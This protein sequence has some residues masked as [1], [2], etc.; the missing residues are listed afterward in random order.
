MTQN[1]D[2]TR[3]RF[4][5]TAASA[6]GLATVPRLP[7][8]AED[9]WWVGSLEHLLPAASH[10]RLAIKCSF[11]D[12]LDVVPMLR[13]G[14]REVA[15]RETDTGRRFFSFDLE[16]LE[17]DVEYALQ[18]IDSAGHSLCDPWPL[19]TFPGPDAEP[20]SVRLVAYTCAGGHPNDAEWFLP[21]DV[22]RRLLR[23]ALSFHPRAVIAIGDHIYWDQRTELELRGEANA[24]R[25]R[26]FYEGVG[27]LDRSLPALGTRNEASLKAAV[28]A[29]D[30]PAVRRDAALDAV[31]LRQRRPRLFR[32]RRR[33][34]AHGHVPPRSLSDRF[35]TLYS[36][37]L[38]PRVSP[39]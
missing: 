26:E 1:S 19:R 13:I 14:D 28:G 3:R 27:W 7:A 35:R 11:T 2:W 16:G 38:P 21:I 33:R 34:S 17:P 5:A 36:A 25:A 32:K 30:Q 20:Q 18:L 22:R 39:R 9:G 10:D 24:R 12:A 15:G 29:A 37:R 8:H 31:V 23:R 6:A 4:V